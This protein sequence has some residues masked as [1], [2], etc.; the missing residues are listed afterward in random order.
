MRCSGDGGSRAAEIVVN[1]EVLK[2]V[3]QLVLFVCGYWCNGV[4]GGRVNYWV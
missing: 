1:G 2:H 3:V 4:R